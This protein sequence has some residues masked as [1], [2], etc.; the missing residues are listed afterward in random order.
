MSSLRNVPP[1][2]KRLSLSALAGSL[3]SHLKAQGTTMGLRKWKGE[4]WREV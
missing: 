1:S 3:P 2:A 4:R